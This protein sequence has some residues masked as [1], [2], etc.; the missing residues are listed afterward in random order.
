MKGLVIDASIAGAWLLA[1]ESSAM[2]D[3]ALSRMEGGVPTF[4]PSLWL[5]ETASL[6]FKAERR[7]RLTRD[8]RETALERLAQMSLTVLPGP[9]IIDLR[10]ICLY[11]EK[12]QL[13]PYDAEYLRVAKEKELTLASLDRNLISAALKEKVQVFGGS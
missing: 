6:L 7:K 9:K 13:T 3:R 4:V 5:L 12:H 1:D 10:L 2:A 8:L 11:A